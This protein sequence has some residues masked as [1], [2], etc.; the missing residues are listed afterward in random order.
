MLVASTLLLGFITSGTWW[1]GKAPD[2]ATA[3]ARDSSGSFYVAGTTHSEELEAAGGGLNARPARHAYPGD[4][5][6][7]K[8]TPS[9]APVWRAVLGGSATDRATAIAVDSTGAVYVAGQ[10]YSLD[11]PATATAF[12][13]ASGNPKALA[14][15]AFVLKL[16]PEGDHLVYAT[17]YG[18][19]ETDR[20]N[21]LAIDGEG[22][23]V[24][25]GETYSDDIPT[26]EGALTTKVC[27]GYGYDGFAAKLNAPGTALVYGTYL[28]GSG[29][30]HARAIALN[31]QG[32]AIIAGETASRDFPV[33]PG[34]FRESIAS[35]NFDAFALKLSPD[36][37]TLEW[38]TYFGGFESERVSALALD[39]RE[40]VFLA[41]E[42]RSSELPGAA[43]SPAGMQDGFITRL[44]ADGKAVEWTRL[45]GGTREER[46]AAIDL[47]PEGGVWIGGWTRSLDWAGSPAGQDDGFVL[48]LSETGDG[49]PQPIRIGG[50]LRD[51]VH[52]IR[53]TGSAVVVAGSTENADWIEGGQPGAGQGDAML[54]LLD[55]GVPPPPAAGET[56]ESLSRRP[57]SGWS[58]WSGAGRLPFAPSLL[59][60]A[61]Q[62]FIVQLIDPPAAAQAFRWK[63]LRGLARESGVLRAR[64]TVRSRQ[65]LARAAIE[66]TGGRVYGSADLVA[67]V[68]F[69]EAD[70]QAAARLRAL[71][72]VK[73]VVPVGKVE[74]DL[75]SSLAT[76]KAPEAW[77]IAGGEASAG[78]Q[79]KLGIV[80]TGVEARHPALADP[81]LPPLEG[82]PRVNRAADL[83][84]TNGKVIVARAYAPAGDSPH[85]NDDV[86]HGTGVA[87]VT[88]AARSDSPLGP[89]TG[90]APAVYLGNY[91]VLTGQAEQLSGDDVVILALEDAAADGM[92]VVNMSLHMDR[93]MLRPEDDIFTDICERMV[94]MGV[95]VVRSTGNEGPDWS[96]LTA[97]HLG[98]WGILVGN[99][100]H[101]RILATKVQLAGGL[102]VMAIPGA[103]T[104]IPGSGAISAP[105]AEVQQIA[106]GT[107]G[108][109]ALPANSLQGTIALIDRGGCN[110]SV[111][112]E[113]A[114]LA[115]A[116]AMVVMALAE[117]PAPFSMGM[118]AEKLPAFMVS[119][120]DGQK[121]RARV[122]GG[123]RPEA[124][125][126]LAWQRYE[127]TP[128]AIS[129]NSS[130]GP[131]SSTL[132]IKPDLIATG[133]DV[134]TARASGGWTLM[135][136]TSL[137]APHVAGAMAVLK[138]HRPHLD[139]RHYRSL[140]IN[141]ASPVT[142]EDGKLLPIVVQ[143][144]GRLNLQAA[145]VTGVAAHP[146]SL[147]LGSSRGSFELDR[148]VKLTNLSDNPASCAISV[149]PR[150]GPPPVV[151]P[152]RVDMG[153]GGEAW[154]VLKWKGADWSPG[155]YDGY[156]RV[157]CDGAELPLSIP[158][159][160]GVSTGAVSGIRIVESIASGKIGQPLFWAA[161]FRLTDEAGLPLDGIKPTVTVKSGSGAVL[162]VVPLTAFPGVY[163]L[164]VRPAAGQTVF[165]ITA[166]SLTREITV[167]GE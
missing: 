117:S 39:A 64:Q 13:K 84:N 21:A 120:A 109:S 1:G 77:E 103:N 31:S 53:L 166:G 75:D 63:G 79:V 51:R 38:G 118:A 76:H 100:A 14:A 3:I 71:D 129:S 41:G 112:G 82:F 61:H 80:D 138:G 90:V 159:W 16:S 47:T 6:V 105:L 33:T 114:R 116:A 115:G 52:A 86:G 48:F 140:I 66:V 81:G 104:E 98:E 102:E 149:E 78:A 167:T 134:W 152:E 23:A 15:D 133:S 106:P 2:E 58:V 40:R 139:P 91:K 130:V 142:G 60:T 127:R 125:I 44:S 34:A 110:F 135:S 50:V 85:A 73:R 88:G 146:T 4:I 147:H 131:G 119:H 97:P 150:Q 32:A 165:Q 9:G 101:S 5:F 121:L 94:A 68:F 30:D 37:K 126:P 87:A 153:A 25:V 89:V 54:V 163:A 17:Y 143:G 18:G 164:H 56:P 162:N 22:R 148:P 155:Q 113:N 69:V 12:R 67:N 46:V 99:H 74:P 10:T 156:L 161:Q 24:I 20:A 36:G 122:A 96:T 154:F 137:A 26:T 19:S 111:K 128:N 83:A 8:M 62:R 42:T 107:W 49:A 160:H 108:C 43:T 136:G 124:T 145:L 28:C 7:Q 123:A 35:P 45:F 57:E 55:A 93:R 92:D 70:E 65:A 151:E 158:Y 29:H 11:F 132:G 157:R 141:T 27:A 72:S 144:A 95:M 59:P